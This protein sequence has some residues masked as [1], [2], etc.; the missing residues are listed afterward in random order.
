ML[1]VLDTELITLIR[2]VV[3]AHGLTHTAI[4]GKQQPACTN[5]SRVVQFRRCVCLFLRFCYLLSSSRPICAPLLQRRHWPPFKLPTLPPLMGLERGTL[6]ALECAA[7]EITDFLPLGGQH[8]RA[9]GRMSCSDTYLPERLHFL[10]RIEQARDKFAVSRRAFDHK[11]QRVPSQLV[12]GAACKRQYFEAA[13]SEFPALR[14]NRGCKTNQL[15]LSSGEFTR[16]GDV[17]VG[18]A[19]SQTNWIVDAITRFVACHTVDCGSLT[20]FQY[21]R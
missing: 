19:D 17:V 5:K 11:L 1:C 12:T 14:A 21:R 9:T 7:V 13:L 10:V 15:A 18:I 8:A 4:G 20:S 6:A 3:V 16:A 2:H